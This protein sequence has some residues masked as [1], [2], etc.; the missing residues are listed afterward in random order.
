MNAQ[1]VRNM[2]AQKF[3]HAYLCSVS[4]DVLLWNTRGGDCL[5]KII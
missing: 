2:F 4:L 1:K 3:I 5:I